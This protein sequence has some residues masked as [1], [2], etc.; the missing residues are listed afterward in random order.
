VQQ[1]VYAHSEQ[2]AQLDPLEQLPWG[3]NHIYIYITKDF[4]GDFWECKKEWSA[5]TTEA[6]SKSEYTSWNTSSV[7]NKRAL[8]HKP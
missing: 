2:W 1:S 3:C 7:W 5:N 4:L 8:G 6:K